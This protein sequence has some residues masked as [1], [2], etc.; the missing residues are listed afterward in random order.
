MMRTEQSFVPFDN[1][2]RLL[3]QP[4]GK[5]Q[6]DLEQRHAA[7]KFSAGITCHVLDYVCEPIGRRRN[8]SCAGS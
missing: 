5:T 2:L 8:R 6:P 4:L 3:I 1:L 7:D